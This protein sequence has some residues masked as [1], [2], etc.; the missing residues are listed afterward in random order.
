MSEWIDPRHA[1]TV[2]H[3]RRAQLAARPSPCGPCRGKGLGADGVTRCRACT[4]TG[5]Q[6]PV[7]MFITS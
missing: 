4:G 3:L 2:A 6:R 7:R 1:E 5:K